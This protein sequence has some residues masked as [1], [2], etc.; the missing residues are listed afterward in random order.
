M[1][2]LSES[3]KARDGRDRLPPERVTVVPPGHRPPLLA[4]R[5]A[6]AHPARGGGRPARA[7]QA[8]RPADPRGVEARAVGPTSRLVIVGE[9]YEREGARGAGRVARRRGRVRFAGRVSDDEL[10]DL[11]RRAW[12]VA[13]ASAREG[14]GMTLTEA[15]ACGTPAVAT[16]IAGHRRVARRRDRPAGR[17][18]AGLARHRSRSLG[19]AARRAARAGALRARPPL[20]VGVHGHRDHAVL[21]DEAAGGP[22]VAPP[23][24]IDPRTPAAATGSRAA[25]P[26]RRTGRRLLR[27]AAAHPPGAGRRRHQDVPV[28]RPGRLLER[29][30]S[31]W[32]PN[33]GLGTVTHQNIGYLWPMGP[34]YWALRAGSASR[35][36]WRSACGWGS[37]LFLAGLGVRFLCAPLGQDA[38]AVAAAMFVYAL[39]PYVLSLAARISA[40]LLPVGRAAVADRADR[41][42]HPRTDV[43]VPRALR[44]RG[45]DHRQHERHR[46]AARRASARCCG[47]PTRCSSPARCVRDGARAVARI[48]VLTVGPSL[49]W[50]AGLWVQGPTASTSC[51]TR[52]PPET[53]AVVLHRTRCCAASAT[54]SS[55]AAT[56]S[57]RG[58]SPRRPTRS[59][60]L[61]VGTYR[62]PVLGLAGGGDRR[63]RHRAYFVLLVVV[64]VVVAVGATRRTTR[65]R[66]AR[67][68]R[69]SSTG[70]HRAGDAQPPRAVPL[71]ALGLSVLLGVG[72]TAAGPWPATAVARR[73]ASRWRWRSLALPPLWT[74]DMVGQQPPRPEDLPSTGSRPPPTSTPQTTDTRACS[75]CRAPTSPPYRWGNT[76]DPITPGLIDRPALRGP[77]AHPLRLAAVGRPAQRVRRPA[78]G[79]RARPGDAIAPMARFMGVGDIVLRTTSAERYNLA[80]PRQTWALLS[81]RPAWPAAGFGGTGRERARPR[82][83]PARRAGAR[84]RRPRPT[85]P[86]WRCSRSRTRSASCAAIP[87]PHPCSWPATATVWST[88]RGRRWSTAPKQSFY[89]GTRSR[90]TRTAWRELD[91]PTRSSSSPTRTA[92]GSALERRS[93]RTGYTEGRR[94]AARYDRPTRPRV[95]P[96]AGDDAHTVAEHRGGVWA[97]RPRTA[98]RSRSPRRPPAQRGRRRPRYRLAGRR[99]LAGARASASSS[100]TTSPAR[101]TSSPCSRPTGVRTG[102]PEVGC[103]STAVSRSTST[104]DRS[105]GPTP[106]RPHTSRTDVRTWSIE[107]LDDDIDQAR[108]LRRPQPGGLRRH[109]TRRRRPPARRGHPAPRDLLD[110]AGNASADHPLAI[111]LT[112]Q[113]TLP[114]SRCGRDAEVALARVFYLPTP[115]RSASPGGPGCPSRPEG[116]I[117]DDLLGVTAADGSKLVASSSRRLAGD[118]GAGRERSTATRAPHWSPAYLNQ[119]TDSLRYQLAEPVS[120]DHLDLRWSPTAATRCPPASASRRTAR[121]RRPWT[122]RARGPRGEGRIGRCRLDFPTVPAATSGSSID[123]RCGSVRRTTGCPAARWKHR[124]ASPN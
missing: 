98:T 14:W 9:G 70:R 105:P 59:L 99:V 89:S 96:D 65:R 102:S 38:P 94:G 74:G 73:A 49:W 80:R 86:R 114:S 64:G 62:L 28:P 84:W 17:R 34:W 47:W 115:A 26:G 3:S 21:A 82:A 116:S 43:A 5:R 97:R 106:V 120:F 68:S 95:F 7:G 79:G 53:V 32:D 30:W 8:L 88:S 31:M 91:G 100:P 19:D 110:A 101:P 56:S 119:G 35:T 57:A 112:R 109:P 23:R 13:S 69:R 117:I 76:V 41:P 122:S 121:P 48:G 44:A 16:R 18:R 37:L 61:L 113:R 50:I 118:I 4:G 10:V 25:P 103:A 78:P 52:R 93:G 75:R 77:R 33:I 40:I 54:G 66:R 51:A 71:V 108:P 46:A 90:P 12:V 67:C 6:H 20:H 87:R 58:S 92:S 124:S 39:S 60:L 111:V 42:R 11:Y 107:V 83:P 27:P 24:P 15:A 2:T 63:W 85:P 45:R 1:V 123:R 36:G 22:S 29:A 55:T 81:G 104:S 72:V